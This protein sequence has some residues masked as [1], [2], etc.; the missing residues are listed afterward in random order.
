MR[1]GTF[2]LGGL[3]GAGVALWMTPKSGQET[4][5][6]IR[7]RARELQGRGKDVVEQG[8]LRATE[9]IKS[10]REMLDERLQQGQELVNN[11]VDKTRQ[12]LESS[13]SEEQ[14]SGGQHNR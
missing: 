2:L 10:G 13:S 6:E 7:R 12:T 9:L 8:R 4:Q 3:I 14:Q 5:D 1:I 11:T